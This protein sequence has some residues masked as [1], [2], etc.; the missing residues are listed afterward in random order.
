DAMKL[1]FK[2]DPKPFEIGELIKYA[3]GATITNAF[4]GNI[5]KL[6]KYR[7]QLEIVEEPPAAKVDQTALAEYQYTRRLRL[8]YWVNLFRDNHLKLQFENT[9]KLYQNAI[10]ECYSAAVAENGD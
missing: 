3:N 1:E 4:T 8:V 7:S 10:R 2:M 5:Q 6:P 9:L